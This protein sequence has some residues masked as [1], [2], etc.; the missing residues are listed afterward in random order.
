MRRSWP[1]NLIAAIVVAATLGVGALGALGSPKA[2]GGAGRTSR[3]SAAPTQSALPSAAVSPTGSS[4][5][6]CIGR[7]E[8]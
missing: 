8:S 2:N 3:G 4:V 6:D 5:P 1:A 7:F